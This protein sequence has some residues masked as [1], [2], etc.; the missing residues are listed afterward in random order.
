[1]LQLNLVCCVGV[2]QGIVFRT[3]LAEIAFRLRKRGIQR[4]D[5]LVQRGDAALIFRDAGTYLIQGIGKRLIAFLC[6][7]IG[8]LGFIKLLFLGSPA[9]R[10]CA[11]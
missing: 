2:L 8:L 3:E 1:M 4:A 7:F 10:E 6:F 11:A 9:M 5:L